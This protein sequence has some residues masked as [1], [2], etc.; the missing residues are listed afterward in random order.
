MHKRHF[1]FVSLAEYGL[2]AILLACVFCSGIQLVSFH[3]DEGEWI[4]SSDAYEEF[5]HFKFSSPVFSEHYWTLTQ[6]PLARYVIGF[7]RSAAGLSAADLQLPDGFHGNDWRAIFTYPD[8]G[9][10]LLITARLP[11]AVMTALSALLL[12]HLARQLAGRACSYCLLALLVFN[13]FLSENL[14]RAMAEAPLLLMVLLCIPAGVFTLQVWD[15]VIQK[16]A[17]NRKLWKPITCFVLMGILAGLAASIKLNGALLL[18]SATLLACLLVTFRPGQLLPAER[19]AFFIRAVLVSAFTALVL[20]ILLNPYLYHNPIQG[21]GRML[22]YR[23]VDMRLQAASYPES[24]IDGS[25]PK[26]A[27]LLFKRIFQDFNTLRFS[28]AGLLNAA[29]TLLG[30]RMMIVSARK[31]FQQPTIARATALSIL[32]TG[33]LV[34]LPSLATPL[35]WDRYYLFPVIFSLICISSGFSWL[36]KLLSATIKKTQLGE[37]PDSSSYQRIK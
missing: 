17:K 21:M 25:L 9:P 29:F 4:A 5:I 23:L 2:V 11:M 34:S 27:F 28:G 6:P 37:T 1:S 36:V 32:V 26:R 33:L 16:Q 19:R 30:I 31:W 8:P 20:F 15:Q 24:R 3:H 14:R 12:F 18:V 10:E 13:P 22:Q 35:N 7:W